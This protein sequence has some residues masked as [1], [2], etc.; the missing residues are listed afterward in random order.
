MLRPVFFGQP[1]QRVVAGMAW[2]YLVAMTA[3]WILLVFTSER[4]LPGTII[5]YGPRFLALYPLLVLIPLSALFART[6]LWPLL[7][8]TGIVLIPIMGAR[9]SPSTL[10]AGHTS[11]PPAPGT[12]RLLTFNAEGGGRLAFD[13]PVM[14]REQQPDLVTFQECGDKL[15]DALA[16]QKGWYTKHYSNL[17]TASRWPITEVDMMPREDLVRIHELGFGGTGLVMRTYL[18]TPHGPLVLINLHLETA[19]KGLEGMLG[20]EGF[21]PDDPLSTVTQKV[22]ES[23]QPE[24]SNLKRFEINTIIRTAESQRASRYASQGINRAPIIVAG[25]FNLPVES[26][27]FQDHWRAFTDAFESRGNGLGWSKREGRWLRIR[28]DHVLTNDVGPKPLRIELG[29]DYSSDHLPV[30]VDLAWPTAR[31]SPGKP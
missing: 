14:L 22:D 10:F 23:V 31:T 3:A 30:I 12:F 26:T 27:I 20:K 13:L 17:C 28:I 11:G 7:L 24:P 25:D 18:D 6:T 19:R 9:I 4:V 16:A 2:A 5:A 15:W 29:P 1:L 8:A 21:I